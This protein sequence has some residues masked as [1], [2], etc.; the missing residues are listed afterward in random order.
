MKKVIGILITILGIALGA[1]ISLYL[2]LYGGI[3]QIINGINPLVAKDIAIGI[4][5]IIFCEIGALPGL[6][7]ISI[8]I[9]LKDK[10]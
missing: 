7:L 3:C 5:K 4:I 10:I 6:V 1:Y 2:M 9:A 8:G